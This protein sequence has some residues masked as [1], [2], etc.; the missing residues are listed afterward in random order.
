MGTDTCFRCSARS[1]PGLPAG[2]NGNPKKIIP[3]TKPLGCNASHCEDILPPKDFP[4]AKTGMLGNNCCTYC[5]AAAMVAC[6]TAGTSGRF[7]FCSMYGKLKR[8]VPMLS[9]A[10]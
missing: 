4:E 10:K 5:K 6:A 2:C 1:V 7:F 9:F 3:F 8:N